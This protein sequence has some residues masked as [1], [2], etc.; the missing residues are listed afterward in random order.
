MDKM[1]NKPSPQIGL[2]KFMKG[3]RT[4]NIESFE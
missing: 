4:V 1:I 2:I 3:V